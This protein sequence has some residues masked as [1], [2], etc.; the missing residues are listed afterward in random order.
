MRPSSSKGTSTAPARGKSTTGAK[1]SAKTPVKRRSPIVRRAD[2]AAVLTAWREG[3]PDEQVAEKFDVA[4]AAIA[5]CRRTAAETEGRTALKAGRDV[6][7][8]AA[9]WPGELAERIHFQAS[10]ERIYALRALGREGATVETVA[11]DR[12]WSV[13]ALRQ[14]RERH[15]PAL[16][17]A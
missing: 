15:A 3:V 11:A 14:L 12:G 1:K 7:A 4:L 10:A 6:D 5:T 16:V 9:R 13:A 2:V 8:V 17:N